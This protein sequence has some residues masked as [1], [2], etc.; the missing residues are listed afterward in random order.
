MYFEDGNVH[1]EDED[2]CGYC[3]NFKKGVACPLLQALALGYVYL[4]DSLIVKN[5]GFFEAYKNPLRIVK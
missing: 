3:A 5:C 2:Q 1:I 4:E